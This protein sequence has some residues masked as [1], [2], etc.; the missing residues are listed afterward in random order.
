VPLRVHVID[1]NML[2]GIQKCSVSV[3]HTIAAAYARCFRQYDSE[4]RKTA[5]DRSYWSVVP[6]S[7]ESVNPF[8]N[9]NLMPDTI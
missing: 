1:F 9:L 8:S 6:A 3:S 7:S 4:T 2:M 5:G